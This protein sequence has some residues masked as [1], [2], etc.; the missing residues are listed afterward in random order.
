MSIYFLLDISSFLDYIVL[1]GGI[2]HDQKEII[3]CEKAFRF[4]AGYGA[5]K[6]IESPGS[7]ERKGS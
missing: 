1:P 7:E 2:V 6:K 4:Q 3:S 5:G